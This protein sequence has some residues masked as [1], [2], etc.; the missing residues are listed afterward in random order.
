MNGTLQPKKN[1]EICSMFSTL[2]FVLGLLWQYSGPYFYKRKRAMMISVFSS[3]LMAAIY[4]KSL[5]SSSTLSSSSSM[6]LHWQYQDWFMLMLTVVSISCLIDN[7]DAILNTY[8]QLITLN[9]QKQSQLQTPFTWFY[10]KSL[11][12]IISDVLPNQHELCPDPVVDL[13]KVIELLGPASR[14][15]K[16]MAALFPI[17]LRQDL[18][19][20]YGFFR[21]CDDLVDDPPTMERKKRNLNL[22]RAY[23]RLLLDHSS[24]KNNKEIK[25]DEND[26][27]I[28][29][30]NVSSMLQLS[31]T[32]DITLLNHRKVHWMSL[33]DSL[34]QH[35]LHFASFRSLAR[36]ADQLCPK[37]ADELCN[38][39]KMDLAGQ[40]IE[41]QHELLHYAALISG[42]FGE[43]CTCVIMYKTGHGNW[44][45][46]DKISR[47]DHVLARA[48]ATGQC[49]QL[50][51]IARDILADSMDSRC[52]VPLNYMPNKNMYHLFKSKKA[53]NQVS[54]QVV[55]SYAEKILDL[56][57]RV[58]D[59]AQIGIDG[60]P[61]EVQDGIRAAFEIY[62]AI[63]PVIRKG[64]VFPL[65]A[66]VPTW[67]KQWIAFRCIYG[68]RMNVLRSIKSTWS[69]AVSSSKSQ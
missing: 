53:I 15:W 25:E 66:K 9:V 37:A 16:T 18:C 8:P 46:Q 22:I 1:N 29:C 31:K 51:N 65:R 3:T 34:D 21:A 47:D 5:L 39:W 28:N 42:K 36:I 7:A 69:R 41:N 40:P 54:N 4:Q 30:N 32:T 45:G 10:W 52:Y 19:I 61:E 64:L 2:C 50:V 23:F 12:M 62:M 44:N 27:Q 20:L 56:A 55:K 38:A 33:F 60:L 68:F 11:F 67:K 17:N 26:D 24:S 57:D 58:S 49:L 13:L 63:G 6:F 48:S 43:L 14:S 35:D 59:K